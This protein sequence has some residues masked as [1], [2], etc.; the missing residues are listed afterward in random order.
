MKLRSQLHVIQEQ[1]KSKAAHTLTEDEHEMVSG[2]NQVSNSFQT[3]WKDYYG[4]RNGKK[5][6]SNRAWSLQKMIDLTQEMYDSK[7]TSEIQAEETAAKKLL[8]EPEDGNG[9]ASVLTIQIDSFADFF[10]EALKKRYLYSD[11]SLKAAHDILTALQQFEKTD[12]VIF[13]D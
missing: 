11:I 1:E 8:G 12:N 10:Y 13:V 5:P 7:W 2:F 3:I 9:S 4:T 6:V